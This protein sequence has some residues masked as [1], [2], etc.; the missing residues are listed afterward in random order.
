METPT[1]TAQK[2]NEPDWFRI[3]RDAVQ[4]MERLGGMKELDFYLRHPEPFIRLQAIRRVATL[5]LP[6]AVPTLAKML[7]DPLEN[8]QNRDEAGWAI[9]RIARAKGLSWFAKTTWTDRYD[10]TEPPASR[11]G[12][13]LA[14]N[15]S[16]PEP[17]YDAA[18][19][20]VAQIEDE[21]LLRIQME[22]KEIRVEFSP[23]PW[24]A[25]NSRYLLKAVLLGIVHGIGFAVSRLGRLIGL[26]WHH[27]AQAVRSAH[28][29]R[30][31][32]RAAESAKEQA[33]GS[34]A[35][36]FHTAGLSSPSGTATAT[37]TT[38][39]APDVDG[40][41]GRIAGIADNANRPVFLIGAREAGYPESTQVPVPTKREAPAPPAVQPDRFA[42]LR[43][44]HPSH[45][46]GR[47]SGRGGKPMFKLLFYPVRLVR[48]HWVFTLLVLFLFYF[49]LA[50]S[51][52]GRNVVHTLN[53]RAL[54][55]NDRLVAVIRVGVLDF[56]GITPV[57]TP[58]AEKDSASASEPAAT[59]LAA[60]SATQAA[61]PVTRRVS[62]PKGL[63][64]R[65][66]PS[67]SG[68][69]IIW[70]P[71]DAQVT[72]LGETRTDAGGDIWQ[73]VAYRD[74]TGWAL[75]KW[76]APVATP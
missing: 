32:A 21:V 60:T 40:V 44:T 59:T 43:R 36:P 17:T 27:A 13:A 54:R 46:S 19:P 73:S 34:P 66:T 4:V 25:R 51:H 48:Q 10:G 37:G 39:P 24:L 63:N 58:S 12:V 70:M 45:R 35:V 61:Q 65:E 71:L 16:S 30:S 75:D 64:L 67:T 41:S 14:A 2:R 6:D 38:Q 9:R 33:A 53:P 50:F 29:R 11:Y 5:L 49:L 76:L 57:S 7:E 52:T 18:G 72:L 26:I 15:G 42:N 23:L 20:E 55:D 69:R 22:E 47:Y 56:F 1:F 68:T 28:E 3:G 8:E 62:A 74:K 31:A